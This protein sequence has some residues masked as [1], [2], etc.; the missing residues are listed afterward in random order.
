M[1]VTV[2]VCGKI[3]TDRHFMLSLNC[4]L[5]QKKFTGCLELELK[6]CLFEKGF[7]CD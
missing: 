3:T 7:L 5:A 1:I 4:L 2:L 6:K